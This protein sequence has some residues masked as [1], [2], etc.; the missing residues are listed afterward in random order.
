[1]FKL[2]TLRLSLPRHVYTI[3]GIV[4]GYRR[5]PLFSVRFASFDAVRK[6]MSNE[7]IFE[8][9]FNGSILESLVFN[10]PIDFNHR[11]VES[12]VFI[13]SACAI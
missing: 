1:M 8:K 13:D 11:S 7:A 12:A 9:Y 2:V 6:T 4:S 10:F 5:G 3:H